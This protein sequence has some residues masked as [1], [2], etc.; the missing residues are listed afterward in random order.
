MAAAG[1]AAGCRPVRAQPL[2]RQ[3]HHAFGLPRPDQPILPTAEL[4]ELRSRLPTEETSEAVEAFGRDDLAQIAQELADVAYVTYGAAVTTGIDLDEVVAAVHRA[5]MS[6]L[7]IDGRPVIID[8][9]VTKGPGYHP[10]DMA[11]LLSG[12]SR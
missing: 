1:T 6:K 11:G 10:P 12:E 3:F 5:N 7:G 8:G 4:A 9:K 2:V